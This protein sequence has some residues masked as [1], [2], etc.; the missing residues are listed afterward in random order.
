MSFLD[1]VFGNGGNDNSNKNTDSNNNSSDQNANNSQNNSN[2]DNNN[3]NNVDANT[4]FW[5]N[6]DKSDAN[7]SS[8]PQTVKVIN[9][10]EPKTPAEQMTAH[11]E[12]LKLTDGINSAQIMEDMRENKT[13]SFDA[14]LATASANAYQAAMKD[15][16]SIMDAKIAKVTEEATA[17]AN[18]SVNSN[19]AVAEMNKALPFTS[20]ADIAPV[21]KAVLTQALKN[22]SST[23]QAIEGVKAFFDKMGSSSQPP[24]SNSGNPQFPGSGQDNNSG[25]ESHDDWLDVLTGKT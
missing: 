24:N 17:N 6:K 19:M 14:A 9:Q 22:S 16:N 8:E 10:P 2:N 11:I 20:D 23:E 12:S 4:S 7:N 18:A 13:E 3:A 25:K 21:A 15:M 1:T 5:D